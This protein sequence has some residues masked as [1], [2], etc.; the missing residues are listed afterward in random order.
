MQASL[1]VTTSTDGFVH[2]QEK[3]RSDG[4]SRIFVVPF[5]TMEERRD[6]RIFWIVLFALLLLT[7]IPAMAAFLSIDNVNLA[8]SLEKFDPRIH[9][10]QPPG[11]PLFVLFGR[12]VNIL[13]RDAERTFIVISL[14]VSAIC[15]LLAFM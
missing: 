12:I 7:R 1:I 6:Q 3:S 13:F 10:P 11:Y 14:I 9:Q 5:A 8:F 4:Q 2:G 15:L